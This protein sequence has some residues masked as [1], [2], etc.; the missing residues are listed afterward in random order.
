[1]QLPTLP[2]LFSFSQI[3]LGNGFV[4]G[5]RVCGRALLEHE[6]EAVWISGVKPVGFAGGGNDRAAA[7]IDFRKNWAAV[8]F[9]IAADSAS[10]AEFEAQCSS[11]LAASEEHLTSDWVQAVS[12][13]RRTKYRDPSL[14]SQDA[15]SKQ[16]WFK[17]DELT[18]HYSADKNDVE[19]G[20]LAAA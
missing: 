8:L 3:L 4:A 19:A 5:V 10:F 18:Q 15:Y 2:L 13:V 16:P 20:L 17:I 9:D 6:D 11:F 1:M 7:F 14:P 12:E